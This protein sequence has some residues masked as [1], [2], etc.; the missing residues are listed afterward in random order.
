MR[1]LGFWSDKNECEMP[2]NIQV[3]IYKEKSILLAQNEKQLLNGFSFFIPKVWQFA[4]S[5]YQA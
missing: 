4:G 5:L 2:Q 3:H 1:G